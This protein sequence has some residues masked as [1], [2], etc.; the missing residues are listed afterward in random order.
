MPGSTARGIAVDI[1]DVTAGYRHGE[2]VFKGLSVTISDRQVTHICGPNGSGK[3]TLLELC[4]GYLRPWAGT[5]TIEGR[6]AASPAARETRRIC[7]TKTALYPHMT[8]RDHLTFASRCYRA[9]IDTVI[10]RARS[11]GLAPWFEA[12]ARALSTGNARKLW[13][14]MCTLGEFRQVFLDEPFLGMDE[15]GG[16][17]LVEDVRRWSERA[18]VVLISHALPDGVRVDQR[19]DLAEVNEG[20]HRSDRLDQNIR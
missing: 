1:S 10:A 20:A 8:V 14:V 2:P 11:I 18:A 7:R 12:D 15:A 17:V 5:V 4:S 9:E 3:S 16:E 6:P 13:Y 19:I